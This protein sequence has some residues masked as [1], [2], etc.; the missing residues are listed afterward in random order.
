MR[1]KHPHPL[2]IYALVY[3]SASHY[4][5][6]DFW[7]AALL[8]INEVLATDL[9]TTVILGAARQAYDRV[10]CQEVELQMARQA[11]SQAIAS[12]L[13]IEG[14]GVGDLDLNNLEFAMDLYIAA[15]RRYKGTKSR[16][17]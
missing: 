10:C 11:L 4:V 3:G 9:P 14:G 16:S 1:N 8:C 7:K 6:G 17:C 13:R 2:Q 15:L 5:R 12:R